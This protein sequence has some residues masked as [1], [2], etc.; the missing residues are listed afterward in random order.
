MSQHL[1]KLDNPLARRGLRHNAD[2][3]IADTSLSMQW[4]A[5]A[6]RSR[7][8]LL[9]E[10]LHAQGER[11]Q[12]LA[13]GNV[14]YEC[15]NV[16]ELVAKGNTALEKA[17]NHA[18]TLEPMHVLVICDGCPNNRGAALGSARSL[19]EDC[20]IDALYIG[21]QSAEDAIGFMRNLAQV[22]RGRFVSFDLATSTPKALTDRVGSLLALPEPKVVTL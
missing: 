16:D 14:P 5:R 17:L 20:I 1:V 9:K 11:I 15:K 4:E 22:G 13:F 21:P 12:I 19:A 3:V 18:R 2:L 10:A 8:S 6:G 7:I